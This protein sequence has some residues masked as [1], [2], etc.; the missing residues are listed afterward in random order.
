[1]AWALTVGKVDSDGLIRVE[2]V[3]YGD[4]K[5]ECEAERDA[6][7]DGCKAFGPALAAGE[8]TEDWSE[9]DAIPEAEDA[10]DD[11]GD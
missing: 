9:I 10:D 11:D 3:F 2:H 7:G 8:V 5:R 6:H 1:M 4:T